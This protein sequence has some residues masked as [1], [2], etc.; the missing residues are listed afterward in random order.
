[1]IKMLSVVSLIIAVTGL[2]AI[3]Q[4]TYT[5]ESDG[6]LFSMPDN[7]KMKIQVCTDRIIRAVYTLQATIPAPEKPICKVLH[8]D[9]ARAKRAAR[10]AP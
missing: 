1:M 2:S 4:I 8:R 5:E 10:S 3:A 6:V 9:Q 7:G